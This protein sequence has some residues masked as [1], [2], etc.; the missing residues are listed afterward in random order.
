MNTSIEHSIPDT[1]QINQNSQLPYE[2]LHSG[3]PDTKTECINPVSDS[4]LLLRVGTHGQRN[5]MAK[6]LATVTDNKDNPTDFSGFEIPTGTDRALII[7]KSEM[8]SE[9]V[10]Q[11]PVQLMMYIKNSDWRTWL[12]SVIKTGITRGSVMAKDEVSVLSGFLCT[13]VSPDNTITRMGF[14]FTQISAIVPFRQVNDAMLA[15]EA[16]QL[17]AQKLEYKKNKTANNRAKTANK[18]RKLNR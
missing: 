13:L 18:S 12:C 7:L 11:V 16:L 10:T 8:D 2:F 4:L 3:L 17:L 15:R 9:G 5:E 6:F 1:V 14:H